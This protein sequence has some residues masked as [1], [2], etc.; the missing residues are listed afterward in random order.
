MTGRGA[1]RGRRADLDRC[2]LRGAAAAGQHRR[3]GRGHHGGHA[4]PDRPAPVRQGVP[5]PV[6][7]RRH[8]RAARRDLG[9]RAGDGRA[10]P[11]RRGLRHLPQPGL[12][13]AAARR[14]AA[15]LRGDVRARPGRG[16]RS[17]RGQ[18]P[19]DVGHVDH[20]AGARPA[21]GRAAGRHPAAGGAGPVADHRRRAVGAAVLQGPGAADLVAVDQV[22]GLDVLLRT[23]E[24]RVLVVAL[25]AAG[26]HRRSRWGS[27]WPTR[28][29]GSPWSTR[30][31]RC[32]SIPRCSGSPAEH[33]LVVTIE[34]NGVV[35]GCGARLA[36]EMRFAEVG[37]PL[38]EFGIPQEFLDHGSRAELLAEVGLTRPGDCPLRRGGHRPRRRAAGA[39]GQQGRVRPLIPPTRQNPV[40]PRLSQA[41]TSGRSGDAQR[42]ASPGGRS[43]RP[44]TRSETPVRSRYGVMPPRWNGQPAAQDQAQVDVHRSLDH[45]LGQHQ[46]DLLGQRVQRPVADLLGGA[47]P[48]ADAQ[49]GLGLVRDVRLAVRR[50]V[51]EPGPL[52]RRP[53]PGGCR[54][55]EAVA[56]GGV[57]GLAPRA[58]RSA[59]RPAGA[60]RTA[61]SAAPAASARRRPPGSGCPRRRR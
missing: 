10:A 41:L 47:R 61:A 20:P 17:G 9:G 53:A 43:R 45:A 50:P 28:G 49:Q 11:G 58:A 40:E 54:H 23:E 55:R 56:E 37:T 33:E 22:D 25:R 26:R 7:R 30:C 57:Q 12:R 46:P 42:V 5:R 3:A 34:D 16:H 15:P 39:A 31:G 24:P 14:R 2:L 18:P 1:R 51:V 59:G 6:L 19:R 8:R 13:P 60:A 44:S 36:Q 4:L 48:V 32:R 29:S 27:G 52:G 35:G 38:R 21:P